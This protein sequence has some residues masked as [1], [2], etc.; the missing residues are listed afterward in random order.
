M[1]TL[2]GT[3][4]SRSTRVAWALEEAKVDYEFIKI[5]LRNG[6]GRTPDYLSINPGGKVP[7]LA[8]D[9][10]VLTESAAI[11]TYIGDRYPESQLTPP[12]ATQERGL[13]EQWCF[14]R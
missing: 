11:V 12:A 8:E 5:D 14:F 13:Y 3:P 1:I 4:N 2:Y 9:G 10:F 6:E 7:A